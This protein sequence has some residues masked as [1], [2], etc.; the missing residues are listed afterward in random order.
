MVAP[1]HQYIGTI[2][3]LE[4]TFGWLDDILPEVLPRL[5]TYML[6]TYPEL[7]PSRVYVTG[8]SGGAGAPD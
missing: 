2:P 7:D 6:E 5:V 8:Y 4:P 1:E 3:T